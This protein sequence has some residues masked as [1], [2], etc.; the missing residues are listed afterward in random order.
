MSNKYCCCCESQLL[1][2]IKQRYPVLALGHLILPPSFQ[3]SKHFHIILWIVYIDTYKSDFR[4]GAVQVSSLFVEFLIFTRMSCA[5]VLLVL[6]SGTYIHCFYFHMKLKHFIRPGARCMTQCRFTI[7]G[8]V[9]VH[10]KTEVWV[11]THDL[12][13]VQI[14]R[15]IKFITDIKF[16]NAPLS[17][18][19]QCRLLK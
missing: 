19:L 14:Q 16:I 10:T 13:T 11:H 17:D 5:A 2:S 3:V 6:S 4:Q 7:K 15:M 18:M 8:S 12:F 9:C 1:S